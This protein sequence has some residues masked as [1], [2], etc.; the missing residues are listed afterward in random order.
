[1]RMKLAWSQQL[2]S[3]ENQTEI[4]NGCFDRNFVLSSAMN[5]AFEDFVNIKTNKIAELTTKYFDTILQ[6]VHKLNVG[7]QQLE[8]LLDD[9]LAIFKF[10]AAKDIFEAFYT[11]RLMRRLL[12]RHVSSFDLEKKL[13]EKF[14]AG[15][16][17]SKLPLSLKIDCFCRRMRKSIYE[18]N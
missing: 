5:Y 8:K 6:K 3:K 7:D 10:L 4:L 1:M 11:K 12:L 9:A 13:V 16:Y 18:E 17:L 15:L 2:S 14:K